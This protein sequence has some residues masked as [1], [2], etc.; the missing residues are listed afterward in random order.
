[1]R[2]LALPA[3]LLV[4]LAYLRFFLHIL[5][6]GSLAAELVACDGGRDGRGVADGN[7][8]VLEVNVILRRAHLLL[9]FQDLGDRVRLSS[10]ALLIKF[11]RPHRSVS[12]A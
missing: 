8:V 10:S 1:M 12:V 5:S 3:V 2:E 9:R 7:L 6:R 11:V 4:W